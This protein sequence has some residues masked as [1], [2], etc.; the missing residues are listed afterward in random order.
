[1]GINIKLTGDNMNLRPVLSIKKLTKNDCSFKD[2][3]SRSHQMGINLPIKSFKPMFVNLIIDFS[4]KVINRNYSIKW[5]DYTGGVI[6]ESIHCIKYY[7]SKNE[8]RLVDMSHPEIKERFEI[9]SLL[10]FQKRESNIEV[11][12]LPPDSEHLVSLF[13]RSDLLKLIPNRS[14]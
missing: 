11:T 8:L 4:E 12:I 2:P 14:V 9:N 5:Y 6:Q 13:G 1:L 3:T 10:I 7:H